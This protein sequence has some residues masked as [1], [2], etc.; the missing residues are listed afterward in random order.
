MSV[1]F[2]GLVASGRA[3]RYSSAIM[4]LTS[5]H[6]LPVKERLKLVN[7]MTA[8]AY[9]LARPLAT[10]PLKVTLIG[11]D[12][13]SQRYAYEGSRDVYPDTDAFLADVVAIERQ[14]IAEVVAEGC[15]YIQID[16]P[17]FTAYV[18][19]PLLEQMQ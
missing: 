9:R 14:M 7:N 2:S 5:F 8:E 19:P 13:I 18:D 11:P 15:R 3:S 6:R 1:T 17:G 10:N 4:L 12:R 16:E